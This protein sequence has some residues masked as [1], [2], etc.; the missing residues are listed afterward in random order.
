MEVKWKAI[1]SS[2]TRK[3]L[4]NPYKEEARRDRVIVFVCAFILVIISLVIYAANFMTR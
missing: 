4:P 3:R 2:M 1:H